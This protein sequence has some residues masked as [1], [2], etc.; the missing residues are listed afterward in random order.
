MEYSAMDICFQTIDEHMVQ[1]APDSEEDSGFADTDMS[2][3]EDLFELQDTYPMEI[4][5]EAEAE[6]MSI[7]SKDGDEDGDVSMMTVEMAAVMEDAVSELC[8]LLN[9]CLL[10]R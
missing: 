9:G 1:D 2:I 7:D 5:T 6:P 4:E 8:K 3:L 10:F